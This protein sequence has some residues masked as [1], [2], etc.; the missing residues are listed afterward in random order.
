MSELQHS[1][2]RQRK[3]LFY[4]LSL[5][6]L[7]WGFTSA[8]SIYGGLI[9]GTVLSM[10]NHWLIS[11]RILSF[12]FAVESEQKPPRLGTSMRIATAALAAIIA[13]RNPEQFHIISTTLGLMAAYAVIMIDFGIQHYIKRMNRKEV[14]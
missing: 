1:I 14:K 9:L 8:Q 12:S 7:G 4:L 3:Y 5:F 2:R 6:F 11:R 13:L 10:C